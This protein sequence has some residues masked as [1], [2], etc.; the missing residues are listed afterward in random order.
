MFNRP[1]ITM[2]AG[3]GDRAIKKVSYIPADLN[4]IDKFWQGHMRMTGS[5]AFV[6]AH[7]NSKGDFHEIQ[8]GRLPTSDTTE[9]E[10]EALKVHYESLFVEIQLNAQEA[11]AK[12]TDVS[13]F[14]E[15]TLE[16]KHIYLIY[17]KAFDGVICCA[18]YST[19][20]NAKKR[21]FNAFF[22]LALFGQF[23]CHDPELAKATYDELPFIEEGVKAYTNHAERY[24]REYLNPGRK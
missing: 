16:D 17:A 14:S 20:P 2:I 19:S 18:W 3:G 8:H 23:N 15:V 21:R 6:I 9:Q 4:L 10:K 13:K 24:Y 5:D 7:I 12:I 22:A 1:N 11:L